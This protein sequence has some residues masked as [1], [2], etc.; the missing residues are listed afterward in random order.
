[1]RTAH[2]HR[3]TLEWCAAARH[4]DFLSAGEEFGADAR[5]GSQTSGLEP[6]MSQGDATGTSN[7]RWEKALA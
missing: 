4:F 7:F 2:R 5:F 1:M 6:P 3:R